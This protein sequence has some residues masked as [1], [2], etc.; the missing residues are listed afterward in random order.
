M[1]ESLDHDGTVEQVV[2]LGG[3][4]FADLCALDLDDGGG[5]PRLVASARLPEARALLPRLLK[6]PPLL[7][8]DAAS[9][10]EAM[11]RRRRR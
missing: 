7:L 8:G 4:R 10:A 11:A 2:R 1:A 5:A 3:E 6:H 9:L